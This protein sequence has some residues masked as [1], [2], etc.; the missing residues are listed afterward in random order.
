MLILTGAPALSRFRQKKLLAEC[1]AITPKIK[2]VYAEFIHFVDVENPLSEQE[3]AILDSLLQY[4]PSRA[5]QQIDGAECLVTPRI[6]T[7]S[8]WSSK[9]TD[10]AQ[11]C[12]LHQVRRIERGIRYVFNGI[13]EIPEALKPLIHDRMTQSILERAEDAEILFAKQSPQPLK[14]VDVIGQGK[15]AL[16]EANR[17]FGLA[18]ADDEI[19]YLV[20][21]YQQLGRNPTDVELMM[22]A[23]ANS[24]HCRHKIFN[25]SWTIDGE[26][27]PLS[28]FQMI[29][30]TYKVSPDGVL[31]AYKDNAAIVAGPTA[32]RFFADSNGIYRYHTE[33][34]H[35]LMKVETHNHPTA[36]SPYPGAATGAGGEIRDEGAT[37]RG[38]K[39]KI[40][41]T[42]FSVSN[43]HIPGYEQPWEIHTGKPERIVSALDI[44]LEGP[45]G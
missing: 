26:D 5:S 33:P 18:L 3:L 7:I 20:D 11:N 29:K 45:I 43:L 25:A 17:N 1:Q 31:S 28:L 32:A 13:T 12:G 4:G 6:G 35:M 34:V 30:N 24:E 27:K 9:A 10:I 23:Q 8:P 44:M 40:G 21:Q 15:T 42:G 38:A 36:I 2:Q 14:T 19:D 39:P 41:L 16:V 37:G 22:F